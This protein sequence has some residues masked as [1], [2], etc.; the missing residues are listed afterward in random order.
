[1]EKADKGKGG[2]GKR[3]KKR[4]NE[5]I[6]SWKWILETKKKGKRMRRGTK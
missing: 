3:G 1:M 4:T 6:D 2:K 5:K